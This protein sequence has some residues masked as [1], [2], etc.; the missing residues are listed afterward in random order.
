MPLLVLMSAT[1]AG[2]ALALGVALA[3][4]RDLTRPSS[5]PLP[6]TREVPALWLESMPGEPN[7]S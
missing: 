2:L 4:L 6:A 7:P 3:L 5:H 1:I